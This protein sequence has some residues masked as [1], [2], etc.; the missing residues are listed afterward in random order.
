MISV[1]EILRNAVLRLIFFFYVLHHQ[2]SATRKCHQ[3]NFLHS[4]SLWIYLPEKDLIAKGSREKTSRVTAWGITIVSNWPVLL[5]RP[6]ID[7]SLSNAVPPST[8]QGALY[9]RLPV[10]KRLTGAEENV[11]AHALLLIAYEDAQLFVHEREG[12]L[13]ENHGGLMKTERQ[14]EKKNWNEWWSADAEEGRARNMLQCKTQ[15]HCICEGQH[16]N[17]QKTR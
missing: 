14:T 7:P 6:K 16:A 5:Q 1:K 10:Q 9:P 12:H 2:K 17:N 13:E 11:F 15:H 8:P 3:H 4:G